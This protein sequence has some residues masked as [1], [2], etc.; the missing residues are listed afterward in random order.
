MQIHYFCASNDNSWLG[1]GPLVKEH[2]LPLESSCLHIILHQL[3]WLFISKFRIGHDFSDTF[4]TN[5]SHTVVISENV[6]F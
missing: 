5:G 4:F 2:D 3:I 1:Q 6:L